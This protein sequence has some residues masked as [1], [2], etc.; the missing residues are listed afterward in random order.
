MFNFTLMDDEVILYKLEK[1]TPRLIFLISFCPIWLLFGLI[2]IVPCFKSIFMEAISFKSY[3]NYM[4]S[5]ISLLTFVPISIMLPI[6]YILNQLIITDKRIYLRKGIIGQGIVI[7]LDDIEAYL[8]FLFR[9]RGVSLFHVV[10]YLKSGKRIKTGDLHIKLG[11]LEKLLEVLEERIPKQVFTRKQIKK[12]KEAAKG[13]CTLKIR[14]N[15]TLPILSLLPFVMALSM[16][17]LYIAGCNNIGDSKKIEVLAIVEQKEIDYGKKHK[18]SGYEL[19]IRETKSNIVYEVPVS[20]T[21]YNSYLESDTILI[22][23]KQGK[24]GI[25]YDQQFYKRVHSR[26]R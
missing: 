5:I 25:I 22:K 20:K 24:L 3:D 18:V 15:Y 14:Q 11:S 19:T 21:I 1:R 2:F 9:S 23:A 13:E 6:S 10:F 26:S 4:F 7:N 17:I 12:L 16:S 8:P